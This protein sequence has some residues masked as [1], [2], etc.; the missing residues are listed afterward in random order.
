M[1]NGSPKA[2]GNIFNVT[3]KTNDR[4]PDARGSFS[5]TEE[6]LQAMNSAERDDQGRVTLDFA[7]WHKIP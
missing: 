5:V 1:S 3:N 4:M 6:M 2:F 7:A